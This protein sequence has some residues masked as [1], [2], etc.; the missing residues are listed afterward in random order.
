MYLALAGG[1]RVLA[2]GEEPRITDQ[3]IVPTSSVPESGKF[4]PRRSD[5]AL[6]FVTHA[7]VSKF[8]Y[9]QI[10]LPGRIGAARS[11][12]PPASAGSIACSWRG[13]GARP[14]APVPLGSGCVCFGQ[15]WQGFKTSSGNKWCFVLLQSSSAMCIDKKPSLR[16]GLAVSWADKGWDNHRPSLLPLGGGWHSLLSQ[17]MEQRT[18]WW[19]RERL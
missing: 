19:H 3:V 18:R 17:L 12:P 10:S 15:P 1:T 11:P 2:Q 5:L 6:K 16:G 7:T 14:P 9:R 4:I 8:C 13:L